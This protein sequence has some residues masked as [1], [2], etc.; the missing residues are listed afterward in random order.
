MDLLFSHQIHPNRH[1][2]KELQMPYFPR[3][4]RVHNSDGKTKLTR[5]LLLLGS[6]QGLTKFFEVACTTVSPVPKYI[7][8]FWDE[9]FSIPWILV[10]FNVKL[11]RAHFAR[12]IN[13]F[14]KLSFESGIISKLS[15]L[16]FPSFEADGY[17]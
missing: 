6:V 12:R 9:S 2:L 3:L 8:S 16:I 10:K 15:F 5:R 4:C 13:A 11:I 1:F 17:A 14:G 7:S